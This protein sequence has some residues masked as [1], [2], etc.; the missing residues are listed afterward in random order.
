V[1][2][3]AGVH[4]G[5]RGERRGEQAA[6]QGRDEVLQ[7]FPFAVGFLTG[8]EEFLLVGAAVAGIEDGGSNQ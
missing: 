1:V 2:V 5:W 8:P 6:L 3:R 7:A 4:A